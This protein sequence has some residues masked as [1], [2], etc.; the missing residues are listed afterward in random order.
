MATRAARNYDYTRGA[1]TLRVPLTESQT[2]EWATQ[3]N[4]QD[5]DHPLAFAIIDNTTYS[6]STELRWTL[7][8]PLFGLGNRLTAGFQYAGTQQ[9]DTNF[10]NVLGNRGAKTKDQINQ[11][12]NL[13]VY[14]EDQLDLTPAFTV[15]LGGR[16]QYSIRAVRDRFTMRDGSR[17]PRRQRLRLGGFPVGLA[18]RG[19]R[20]ARR[21]PPRRC[22]AMPARPTSRRSSW[23]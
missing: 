19:L 12:T 17:G 1:L 7:A 11:A 2:F 5:L 4:Y 15:V 6:W 21:R 18:S 10:A 3:L 13:G 8:A 9:I 16:G 23:S 14:V 20:L 22:S